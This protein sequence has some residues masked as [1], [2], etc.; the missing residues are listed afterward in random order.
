MLKLETNLERLNL[1]KSLGT[2]RLEK[3]RYLAMEQ[4][5]NS[6]CPYDCPDACGLVVKVEDNVVKKVQGNPNH[7]FTRG[8]LCQKMVHYEKTVHSPERLTTPLRRVGPK[9]AGQFEPC[10]WEEATA[11]IARQFKKAIEEYG[12]ESIMPYSYAGTMGLI[13]SAA[14][15]PLFA[16]LGA[17]RQDRGICSP[18][19]RYAWQTVMGKTLG[20]RPQEMQHSDLVILWSLNAVATNLHILHDV[21][22]AKANGSK[23]W[24][25]DVYRSS[26]ADLAD[27]VILTKPGSDGALALGMM[28]VLAHKGL[29][30][31]DFVA[32]YVQGYEELRNEVLPNYDLSTVAKLTGVSEERIEELALAYGE[33]QAPFIRLGSG[34]SRYGN[35]AM[36]VRTITCLPALVGAYEK[37]GGGFLGSTSGSSFVNKDIMAWALH[38]P[39][40]KKGVTNQFQNQGESDIFSQ[41][42]TSLAHN[43][44]DEESPLLGRLIPMVQLGSALLDDVKPIKCLYV[45]SSNPAIT[46]PDQ[47]IVC[48]GLRRDDLFT[49]VH[50]RFMT[51]TAKYADI[52]LP[53]T[54]ALEH[55]DIYNSYG[56]YTIGLGRK[57]IEPIG[58]SKSNWDA[59]CA[60]AKALGFT[61]QTFFE[62]SAMDL[63]EETLRSSALSEEQQDRVLQGEPVEVDLPAQYKMDFKTPSGKIEIL[64]PRE[65]APLPTYT[66]PYGD[67]AAYWLINAPDPRILDSSF[68]ELYDAVSECGDDAHKQYDAVN[69]ASNKTLQKTTGPTSKRPYMVAYMN[70]TESLVR[71]LK[72]GQLVVLKNE[73]GQVKLPLYFDDRV[74]KGTV[75]TYGVWW[76]R[77]SS[78]QSVSI[79]ALTA[80]RMTDKGTGST[81]Y[82]VKVN[83]IPCE[84]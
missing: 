4:I 34:L 81:F 30:N 52:V 46:L 40:L 19:K 11:E 22:R 61:D 18:A 5:H 80:S 14:G 2:L 62:R 74:A 3:E 23:V 12:G 7:S 72:E 48:Q 65:E 39:T 63:V 57:L 77:N 56:H 82:D 78:D 54:S 28:N 21:K 15:D 55:D 37:R 17:T 64:N 42:I 9:G 1:E 27:E 26:T 20:T 13:Q 79:N 10:S 43:L 73:R 41:C 51:D 45:Y 66:E 31:E 35:G 25:I 47:N 75:L 83:I 84:A 59:I 32:R 44:D 16:R 53:A 29:V 49:V 69:E 71:E 33:A 50:E 76:Q 38:A 8:T 60:I 68:N 67:D 58:E 24:V 6:V 36:T 70:P